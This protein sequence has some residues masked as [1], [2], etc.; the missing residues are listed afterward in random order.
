MKRFVSPVQ[1]EINRDEMG[2]LSL[3][4]SSDLLYCAK[5]L[6]TCWS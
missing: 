3:I 6:Y 5:N 1:E 4:I 2:P